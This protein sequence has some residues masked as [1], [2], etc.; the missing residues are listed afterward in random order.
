MGDG[1][2]AVAT[3]IH[4]VVYAGHRHRLRPVPVGGGEGEGCRAHRG[5]CCAG[6]NCDAHQGRRLAVQRH[7]VGVHAAILRHRQHGFRHHDPVS[8]VDHHHHDRINPDALVGTA[9]GAGAVGKV[10]GFV[11]GVAVVQC[12]NRHRLCHTPVPIACATSRSVTAC[13][14][15]EGVLVAVH[16][17]VGI[18]IHSA[19]VPIVHGDRHVGARIG[20][21]HHRVALLAA[22]RV[23]FR[24]GKCRRTNHHPGLGIG[25]TLLHCGAVAV[26]GGILRHTRRHI[27][28][29]RPARRRDQCCPDRIV[30]DPTACAL[31]E[32]RGHPIGNDDI[33]HCKAGHRL[34]EGE[35]GSEGP[36]A[37]GG[38]PA[39]G[40]R[41]RSVV[42]GVAIMVGS[43]WRGVGQPIARRV[44]DVLGAGKAQ[45]HI[46]V[47][48][49]QIPA[50]GFDIIGRPRRTRNRRHGQDSRCTSDPKIRSV[51][52]G[53]RFR[54]RHPPGELIG[55]GRC[56]RRRLPRNGGHCRCRG[57]Q[58]N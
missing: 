56:T 25:G 45:R 20:V 1:G 42:H 35:G 37:G 41:R 53:H 10:E 14:E 57:V 31:G 17:A 4:I 29:D 52:I 34:R 13:S 50:R 22:V 49:G 32:S 58:N 55:I 51:H 11:G 40:H 48:T 38:H 19:G 5:C 44:L 18:H 36:C 46:G 28:C 6:G 27:H 39:D 30:S 54:K 8:C 2:A 23:Q 43:R 16:A 15:D 21:Q 33:P 26:A 24:Q 47:E 9:C 12:L 3:L 7:R